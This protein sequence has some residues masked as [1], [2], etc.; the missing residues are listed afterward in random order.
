MTTT[1]LQPDPGEDNN[2]V[3]PIVLMFDCHEGTQSYLSSNNEVL[4][5]L[6]GTSPVRCS[7]DLSKDAD[8]FQWLLEPDNP[9]YRYQLLFRFEDWSFKR[10]ER[11]YGTSEYYRYAERDL[12]SAINKKSGLAI[13][14][15]SPRTRIGQVSWDNILMQ[16]RVVLMAEELAKSAPFKSIMMQW[17]PFA[18]YYQAPAQRLPRRV[19]QDTTPGDGLLCI[20]CGTK[21]RPAGLEAYVC[22]GC[23]STSMSQEAGS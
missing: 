3:P 2:P 17:L 7:I 21:M 8:N 15:E 4:A 9:E 11:W 14:G 22:E 23:G 6:F 18:H 10:L 16:V 19:W 12:M 13:E 1:V 5:S 20:T